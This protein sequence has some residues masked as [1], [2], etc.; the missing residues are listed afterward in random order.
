MPFA[1]RYHA[2]VNYQTGFVWK[3]TGLPPGIILKIKKLRLK[4]KTPVQDL[5]LHF[6]GM[7]K[8]AK[9]PQKIEKIVKFIPEKTKRK[10][11]K[12]PNV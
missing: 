9:F 12:F 7:E 2:Q 5:F 10:I 3:N 8:L 1:H 6:F 11:L 4:E